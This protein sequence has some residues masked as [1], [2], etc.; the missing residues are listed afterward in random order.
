MAWRPYD[1][2][3]ANR[4]IFGHASFRTAQRDIVLDILDDKDVFVLLPTGGGKSLCFQLP[5]VLSCGVTI[6][7]C[8]LLALMQDQVQALVRGADAA[9]PALRGVPATFLS[10]T[11]KVGHANA[12][13]ADLERG[14]YG[15]GQEPITKCLYVTPE[16]L[17]SSGR[18]RS[19]LQKLASCQPRLLARI[20]VDEAHCVSGWG[21]D[22]RPDYKELGGLR[23]LLPGVP[24]VALTA[25]ATAKCVV[26]IRKMLK[27]RPTTAM[28]QTSFNR[29][30]L[31]YEVRR[32]APKDKERSAEQ[33]ACAQLVAY[34]KTWPPRTCGIVYCLSQAD[35][36]KYCDVLLH[37]GLSAGAYHAGMSASGRRAAQSAWMRG[38][39]AGGFA[40]MCATIAMGMGIDQSCVRFVAHVCLPKSLEALYQESG[41][42]GR[43]GAYSECVLFYAPKDYARVV[44]MCRM[45]KG[46]RAAKAKDKERAKQV[47][48]YCEASDGCCR[49][50]S[51]LEHFGEV[52]S[53]QLCRFEG[54][55]GMCDVCAPRPAEGE[56]A[57][58]AV[59]GARGGGAAAA[60]A[61]Q[62]GTQ[63]DEADDGFR[64]K[65]RKRLEA[66]AEGK[67]GA[68]GPAMQQVAA[69]AAASGAGSRSAL[70]GDA[71]RRKAS[72]AAKGA[73]SAPPAAPKVP[74]DNPWDAA[75]KAAPRPAAPVAPAA[76]AIHFRGSAMVNAARV[77]DKRKQEPIAAA[78]PGAARGRADEDVITISDSDLS[79]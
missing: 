59:P 19:A 21:H 74:F 35:T 27:M 53:A 62:R 36:E 68:I 28:H 38:E 46:T 1:V 72:A 13:F 73:A 77:G 7:V 58:A 45:G 9:D 60:A 66:I 5:A 15:D 34:I 10:S 24:I 48:T 51:L 40:V 41:R 43:D 78:L 61:E 12:V 57:A 32:K 42:A 20:V 67:T 29:P 33:A 63:G 26:D 31:R 17:A 23:Q 11:A 50:V 4:H 65:K 3:A 2:D 47:K 79:E 76:N 14:T 39:A 8:P 75:R 56:E 37:A 69:A 54:H 55:S 22:F 16:Q 30:N 6:V 18:L 44:H 49:R 71:A 52:A 70:P 25:T 64:P